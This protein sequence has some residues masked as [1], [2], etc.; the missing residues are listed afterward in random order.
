MRLKL[1]VRQLMDFEPPLRVGTLVRRYKRFLADI[2]DASGRSFTLHCPNPG[3]M[4]GCADPGSRVW[5]SQSNNVNRKYAFTLEIVETS[6]GQLVGVNPSRANTIVSEALEAKRIAGFDGMTV[7]RE[8]QIPGEGG[9]FDFRLELGDTRCYVEV[10][11]VTLSRGDGLGAFPDA[12]SDR[13]RRHV[14]SLQR[15]RVDGHRAVL[16]FC[17]QHNGIERVTTADDID[18]AYG[19]AVRTAV[20]AGVEVVAFRAIVTSRAI[21]LADPIPVC[22]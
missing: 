9:R 20:E 11:S 4:S 6:S 2:I 5:Y 22:L 10:K 12:K 14:T 18:A 3:A 17:V 7:H 15:M 19:N 16:L 8:S 13:A 1:R 21:T